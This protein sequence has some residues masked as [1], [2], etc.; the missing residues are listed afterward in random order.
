MTFTLQDPDTGLYWTTGIFG[1]VQLGPVP[2]T[3]A[4]EGSYIKN[5][6]TGMYVNHRAEILHEGG[7]P[8]A[9]SF[10]EDGVISSEGKTIGAGQFLILGTGAVAWIKKEDVP[11][12]RASALIEEALKPEVEEEPE[13]EVEPEVEEE[14]EVEVEPEVEPEE[15]PEVEVEPEVEPEVEEGQE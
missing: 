4:L 6:K 5:V 10:G 8:E 14:P 13:V 1:R 11:V 7:E 9:F 12:S 3:Y 15:E 2:N